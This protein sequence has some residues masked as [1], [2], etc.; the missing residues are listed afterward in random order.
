M[1]V[2]P[3]LESATNNAPGSSYEARCGPPFC[4]CAAAILDWLP[5]NGG[6]HVVLPSNGGNHVVL[7]SNGGN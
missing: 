3:A 4:A 5:S 1:I 2:V 6:N 7:P